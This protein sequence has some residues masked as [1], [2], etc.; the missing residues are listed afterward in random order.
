MIE[1]YPPILAERK[2]GFYY[3]KEKNMK[4]KTGLS[5]AEIKVL[6]IMDKKLVAA[7]QKHE[8]SYISK[9]HKIPMAVVAA[10]TKKVGRSRAKVYAELRKQG[11]VIKTKK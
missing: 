9:R 2:N 3:L 11:Y 4:K 10:A 8:I 7:K 6:K 5:K 1:F